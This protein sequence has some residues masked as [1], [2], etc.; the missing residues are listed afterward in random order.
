MRSW[1]EEPTRE[2]AHADALGR[3]LSPSRQYIVSREGKP[4]ARRPPF[5]ISVK[6]VS[7]KG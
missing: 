6:S 4:E 7:C 2:P 5:I 3:R 1:I